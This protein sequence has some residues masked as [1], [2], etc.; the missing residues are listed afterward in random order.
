MTLDDVSLP[1]WYVQDQ[2]PI[3]LWWQY[4]AWDF[5]ETVAWASGGGISSCCADLSSNISS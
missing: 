2:K 5:L 1:R 3:D 4:L